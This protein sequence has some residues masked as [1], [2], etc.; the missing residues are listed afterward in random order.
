[1]LEVK[2]KTPTVRLRTYILRTW[3]THIRAEKIRD[4]DLF[5]MEIRFGW[6]SDSDPNM[7]PAI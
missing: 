1:M 2:R 5:W 4:L 3:Y 6:R 7:N